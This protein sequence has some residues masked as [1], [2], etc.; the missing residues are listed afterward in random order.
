MKL[1]PKILF[2]I[3]LFI[4]PSTSKAQTASVPGFYRTG[5]GANIVHFF[6]RD[7]IYRDKIQLKSQE[8]KVLLYKGFAV[9]KAEY[10]MSNLNSKNTQLKIAIPINS[11]YGQKEINSIHYEDIYKLKV[12]VNNKEIKTEK[13]EQG[14]A[15]T[16]QFKFMDVQSDW[17]YWEMDFP[18]EKTSKIT[19][20]YVV[21]TNEGFLQKGYGSDKDNGFSFLSETGKIW[22][23]SIDKSTIY[24]KLM[25]GLKW[26]DIIGIYPFD[27]FKTD[28]KTQMIYQSKNIDPDY[29][30]NILIRYKRN[31]E[32]IDF[33]KI[34]KDV[35]KYYQILDETNLKEIN[36][37]NFKKALAK[38]FKVKS[39]WAG[40]TAFI[41]MMLLT[42]GMPL[43]ILILGIVFIRHLIKKKKQNEN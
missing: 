19:L 2:L 27:T 32:K 4:L 28:S 20:Y 36:T 8:I 12:L 11:Y 41:L 39:W 24:I 29:Q 22:A 21:N 30:H 43:M 5:G 14:E 33:D 6:A 38:D 10:L 40:S 31:K 34:Q 7:S 16:T 1:Y 18:A 35:K 25:E 37:K 3:L 13:Q 42:F 26:K 15:L 23:K 9:V 17:Y